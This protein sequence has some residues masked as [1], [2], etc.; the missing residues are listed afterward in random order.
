MFT[1]RMNVQK[2]H[3][4]YDG[5]E[6]WYHDESGC[7]AFKVRHLISTVLVDSLTEKMNCS[8]DPEEGN[9]I[10]Q[11]ISNLHETSFKDNIMKE[12]REILFQSVK[13]GRAHV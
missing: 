1:N 8:T 13:I 12:L 6:Q 7:E 10:K 5:N 4:M 2:D 11:C 3:F 9:D